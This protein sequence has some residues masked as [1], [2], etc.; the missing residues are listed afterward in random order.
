MLR[1]LEEEITEAADARATAKGE[2]NEHPRTFF[3]GRGPKAL[4]GRAGA[5][6][7]DAVLD[8]ARTGKGGRQLLLDIPD[9]YSG[10]VRWGMCEHEL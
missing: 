5:M 10:C 8:W 4:G 7:I 9:E 6:R 1:G 3:A 2:T